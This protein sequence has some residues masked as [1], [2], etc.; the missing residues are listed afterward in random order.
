MNTDIDKI[1]G[2]A[3]MNDI[4]AEPKDSNKYDIGN[5]GC[6]NDKYT[7][8]IVRDSFS[9][10]CKRQIGRK[11]TIVGK[12]RTPNCVGIKLDGQKNQKAIHT[13]FLDMD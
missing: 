6:L 9:P 1:P 10:S 7:K 11:F 12:S 8:E 3:T 5:R 4:R 2:L 13:S